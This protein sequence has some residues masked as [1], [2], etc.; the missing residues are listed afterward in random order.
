MSYESAVAEMAKI[1]EESSSSVGFVQKVESRFEGQV[2]L[3]RNKH[4]VDEKTR[5]K[6]VDKVCRLFFGTNGGKRIPV[7]L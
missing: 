5:N 1:A 6:I 4:K 3:F 7:N 2:E